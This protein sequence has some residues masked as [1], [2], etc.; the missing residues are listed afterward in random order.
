[1]ALYGNRPALMRRDERGAYTA[2]TY[3]ELHRSVDRLARSLRNLGIRPGGRVAIL[4]RNCPE[5]VV[6]DLAAL[7]CGAIVVPLYTT[8]SPAALKYIISDSGSCVVFAGDGGFFATVDSLRNE[9]GCVR[10]VIVFDPSG[11]ERGKAFISFWPLV[12]ETGENVEAS[13]G[14][15]AVSASA[16]AGAESEWPQS[17]LDDVATIVYTSGTTGEPKGVVLSHGNILS[18]AVCSRA[19]FGLSPKDRYLS[20]LPLSHTFERTGG[21][22]TTL[23]AG[24]PIAYAGDITTIIEDARTIRP[25]CLIAVPRILEKVYD[26]A[27]RK[28]AES[29]AFRRRLVEAAILSLNQR[30]NL[31]YRGRPV[32]VV[33]RLKC[34][35]YDAV[36]ARKF[37]NIAGGKLRLIVSG[38]APLD[39]RLAKTLTAL[40]FNLFEGYGLTETS[41]SVSCTSFADNRLG[42][43]GKPYD[44]VEV[45][46]GDNSEVLV[47][48]PNVM[49]GYFNKPEDTARAFDADGWFLTGDQGRFDR[50]GN[51]IITGRIK[52]L[53]VTSYGKNVAPVPIETAIKESD[54]IEDVML[55]GDR[56]KYLVAVVVAQR[57][58]VERYARDNG[59]EAACYEELLQTPAVR[60]LIGSEIDKATANCSSYEK[61]KAFT[62]V[63]EGFS[64]A[65]DL[66]TP[67]LKLR[68]VKVA[69]KYR[70]A[71]EIM[72]GRAGTT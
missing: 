68:R 43:V 64:V 8:L 58:A 61:V 14:V 30:V 40:G 1:M 54:Y 66:I 69:E 37:R 19:R 38:A 17:A 53:I 11:I 2:I 46:I 6:A 35:F 70:D 42:P 63:S 51:L 72:Y 65:N 59:M 27:Q 12:E 55:Y 47:K 15:G 16:S 44:G 52:E 21:Y 60:A 4:A 45:K 41:P 25:T 32:P 49:K 67:T 7:K 20:F 28:V 13:G 33:L 36:V 26:E 22:Y 23:L 9:L 3:I 50:H 34:L 10:E 29:S 57:G 5:W 56:E 62:V 71:I 24:V 39:R 48:G 31:R 18:N